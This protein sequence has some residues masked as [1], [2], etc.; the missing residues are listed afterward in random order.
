MSGSRQRLTGSIVK[1]IFIGWF[2][3][4]L[5]SFLGMWWHKNILYSSML[6][7]QDPWLL[8]V[9][10]FTWQRSLD[11]LFDKPGALLLTMMVLGIMWG[12]L[13]VVVTMVGVWLQPVSL[14]Q[15]PFDTGF[16]R[17]SGEWVVERGVGVGLVEYVGWVREN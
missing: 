13:V 10:D 2:V 5:C 1:V 7:R 4:G 16:I 14:M 12:V 6:D 15:R 9:S 8:T 3:L 11:I 17:G